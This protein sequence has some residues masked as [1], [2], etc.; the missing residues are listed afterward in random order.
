MV[1][2]VVIFVLFSFFFCVRVDGWDSGEDGGENGCLFVF[3]AC[4]LSVRRWDLNTGGGGGGG[5]DGAGESRCLSAAVFPLFVTGREARATA[6]VA[7][8]LIWGSCDHLAWAAAG[9]GGKLPGRHRV[10]AGL[11]GGASEERARATARASPAVLIPSRGRSIL[12]RRRVPPLQLQ[13]KLS[14]KNGVP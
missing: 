11:P 4:F 2:I 7:F 8:D 6:N 13:I 5:T 3:L 1:V 9:R 10:V 12:A 14:I